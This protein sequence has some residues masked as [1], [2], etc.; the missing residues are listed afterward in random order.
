MR[1][2][3]Y[4]FSF[5]LLSG[6][7]SGQ[8]YRLSLQTLD[9]RPPGILEDLE[10]PEKYSD[11][12][13][14]IR[15]LSQVILQLQGR[16][17]LEAS[18][19]QFKW[20]DSTLVATLHLG[21]VY[22]WMELKNGNVEPDFLDAVGFRERLYRKQSFN[23]REV[24]KLQESLLEYAE[25]NG[26]PF[27]MVWLDSIQIRNGK[28]SGRLMQRK[29]KLMIFDGI[30]LIGEAKIS[31]IYLQ[32]YLGIKPGAPYS[33]K[34]VLKIQNRIKEL[35]FLKEQRSATVSF[36]G[37]NATVNVFLERKKASRFDFLFGFLPTNTNV[38][39]PNPDV[40]RFQF[41]ATFNAD[42]HN[43]FGLGERIFMEFEQLRPQT[44]E[45]HLEVEYPYIL[46]LPFGLDTKFRLYKRDTSYL[47]LEFDL[48]VQYL[49]EG[50]NY[51]K[52]F[53]NLTSTN[54]LSVD[55]T[56]II[57]SRRLPDNLDVRN[58]TFGLEYN[59]Q[60]LD[61]RFNP[62]RGWGIRLR[63]GAGI[64]QIKKNNAIIDLQDPDEPS[65]RYESLYDTLQER[66]FQYRMSTQLSG[67][68]PL[69]DNSA[70]KLS[71]N[72]GMV[73][74][75]NA[76]YL[77]EQFRIGGNRLM[78]GYDEESIF[79]TN[80]GIATLEY[81]L[82]IGLNS[83][84]YAFTDYGYVENFTTQKRRVE[85]PLGFGAGITFETGVGIFGFS[86]ALGRLSDN[87][88]DFRNLKTHFGY[89]SYF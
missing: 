58:S 13:S 79:A 55:E 21:A 81:R 63:G 16:A 85:R 86:L 19:E 4:I 28:I 42:M 23:Y 70:L 10:L 30:N 78:R 14:T 64:K 35:P 76:I 20:Q 45:L 39:G 1:L 56:A 84:L 41:T 75:E 44:Q 88:Y 36:T 26:Y 32:N 59:L 11:S 87:S 8:T 12:L 33:K 52:A 50:G 24:V 67:F 38:I 68:L 18:V 82:L 17:Y 15:S 40:R 29:N 9:D 51:L 3:L 2:L 47:D 46:D 65:F 83:Y 22:E 25:N 77:N 7:L 31:S 62:R 73:I 57:N 5:T 60:K 43:Q 53:W 89:V 37:E 49:L 48:G 71:F 66:S 54:I 6:N 27:A 80:Y 69:F 72:G 74:S 34:Q 61:Y